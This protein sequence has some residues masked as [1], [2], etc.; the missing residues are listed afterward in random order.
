[1]IEFS[2]LASERETLTDAEIKE[3]VHLSRYYK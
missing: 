3:L 1:M 2:F